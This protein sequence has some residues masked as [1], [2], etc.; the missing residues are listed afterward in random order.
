MKPQPPT[1]SF[2]YEL[3]RL[4]READINLSDVAKSLGCSLAYVSMCEHGH[5][6]PFDGEQ[7]VKFCNLIGKPD[8][9]AI[10]ASLARPKEEM[11]MEEVKRIERERCARVVEDWDCVCAMTCQCNVLAAKIRSGK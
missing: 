10:L 1:P 11:L 4:R 2:G 7:I 3:R 8:A 6:G 9:V 5:R